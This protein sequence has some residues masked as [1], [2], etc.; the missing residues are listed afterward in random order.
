MA[1]NL[2]AYMPEVM[3]PEALALLR[4]RLVLGNIVHR[5]FE[6]AVSSEGDTVTF[7]KPVALTSNVRDPSSVSS[8]TVTDSST[9]RDSIVLSKYR[10]IK[11]LVSTSDMRKGIASMTDE[12]LAPMVDGVAQ[13]IEADIA[14][15][16]TGGFTNAINDY[17][18]ALVDD[19]LRAARLQLAN[20]KCPTDKRWVGV[21]HHDAEYDLLGVARL[22]EADMV[23]DG[24]AI[25]Q[26]TLGVRYNITWVA[27]N[28]VPKNNSTEVSNAVMHPDAI[29]LVQARLGEAE[30]AAGS[31][32][33]SEEG[34]SVRV[35]TDWDNDKGATALCVDTLYGVKLLR[36]EMGVELKSLGV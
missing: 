15:I 6:D 19:D 28:N 1:N 35:W 12:I 17:T 2:S 20:Q 26:A 4:N 23:G 24:E 10:Y 3:A 27:S 13:G 8:L 5:D 18:T 34:Y 7:R 29:A 14:A 22:T 9:E 25:R 11:V 36:N 30:G 16:F 32:E 33:V 31:T 21:I